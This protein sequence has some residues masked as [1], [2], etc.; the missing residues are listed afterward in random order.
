MKKLYRACFLLKQ[1]EEKNDEDVFED[2]ATITF[3][4]KPNQASGMKQS[5]IS[6]VRK[7]ELKRQLMSG[8]D[9]NSLGL[10]V[11]DIFDESLFDDE[12]IDPEGRDEVAAFAARLGSFERIA[13]NQ[14]K[15]K[16][17]FPGGIFN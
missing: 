8:Q 16:V 4:V 5:A 1:S 17:S 10:N 15:I 13:S 14:E 6:N 11:D 2:R 9:L 7:E 3:A 12:D